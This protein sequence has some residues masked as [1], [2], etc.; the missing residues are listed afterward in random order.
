MSIQTQ[1]DS[2]CA[3]LSLIAISSLHGRIINKG[4]EWRLVATDS[5]E[6]SSI[7]AQPLFRIQAGKY[8]L[9]ASCK[10]RDFKLGEVELERTKRLTHVVLLQEADEYDPD[11]GYFISN[12]EVDKISEFLRRQQER[13]GIDSTHELVGGPLSD[14]Y[15]REQSGTGFAAHPLLQGAMFDGLPP[16]MKIDPAENQTAVQMQLEHKH[17]HQ[18]AAANN[19]NPAPTR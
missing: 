3:E 16:D 1:T 4:I 9:S 14:P 5:T 19:F 8:K 12:D 18:L 13:A 11:Q 15:A 6:R 7:E 17:Q 2:L 10:G